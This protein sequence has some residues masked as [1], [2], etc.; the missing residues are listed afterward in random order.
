MLSIKS[1]CGDE[2][3]DKTLVFDEVDTGIGGRVA[4]AVGKRLREISE[5]NQVLCVTH[6]PQ[7]AAFARNH[8]SVSKQVTGG[9]TETGV[10]ALNES[11]RIREISRM[12][13]GETVTEATRRYAVDMLDRSSRQAAKPQ[14]SR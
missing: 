5:A 10:R 3:G 13:G 7:I 12:L 1:L 8:Y 11:E 6:L 4:E 9:R 14:R 2:E